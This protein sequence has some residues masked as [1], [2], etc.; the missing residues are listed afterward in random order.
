MAQGIN[1]KK[2]F[3]IHGQLCGNAFYY[4]FIIMENKC[5]ENL[6][7]NQKKCSDSIKNEILFPL[8]FYQINIDWATTK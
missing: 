8:A 6:M 2:D 1:Q 5:N 7:A 3:T 4:F